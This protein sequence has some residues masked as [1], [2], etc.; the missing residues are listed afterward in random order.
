MDQLTMTYT[1]TCTAIPDSHETPACKPGVKA[2]AYLAAIVLDLDQFGGAGGAPVATFV[3]TARGSPVSA[4][5][6]YNT[7][8]SIAVSGHRVT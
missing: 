5:A 6:Q 8:G 4:S 1:V 7:D 3:S 2:E